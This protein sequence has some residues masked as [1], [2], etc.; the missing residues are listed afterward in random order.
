MLKANLNSRDLSINDNSNKIHC[1][2]A[3]KSD[4][5]PK[6]SWKNFFDKRV[7][8]TTI[9]KL[10][11]EEIGLIIEENISGN[12]DDNCSEESALIEHLHQQHKQQQ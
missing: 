2:H 11:I 10:F 9:A 3:S 6:K 5:N 7:S 8:N 1:F 4:R 12:N